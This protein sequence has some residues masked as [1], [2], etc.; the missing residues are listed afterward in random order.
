MAALSFRVL[1]VADDAVCGAPDFLSR[2]S[3]LGEVGRDK[4]GVY[5]RSDDSAVAADACATLAPWSTPVFVRRAAWKWEI[6]ARGI[7]LRSDELMETGAVRRIRTADANLLASASVHTVDEVMR[8]RDSGCAFALFGHVFETPSKPGQP[9]RGITALKDACIAAEP[10]PVFA[11]GGVTPALVEG[12]RTAGAWGVA[13]VRGLLGSRD[14][15][16]L[17]EAFLEKVA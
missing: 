10:M 16:P 4:V 2:L 9:G 17:L 12:C 15:R 11:L 14:P 1:A 13:A 7:H 5:V 6:P 3:L 8:A